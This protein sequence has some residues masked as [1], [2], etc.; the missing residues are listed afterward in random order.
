MNYKGFN[1]AVHEMGHNVEQTFSLNDVDSTLPPGRAEHRL[2]RG[3]RLRLPGARPRAA[4]PRQAR[5]EEPGA[6]DAERLLDDL[7]DRRRGARRH[8]R[9]ALD[10]RPPRRD[11][12]AAEGGDAPD[13]PRPLEQVLRA[14]LREEGRRPDARHLLPHDRLV[15]LPA[16]L[17]DRP[18][19][20]VPDRA[21]D[22]E[23][24]Q[25]RPR[26]RA[27]GED[28]QRRPGH[29]DEAGDRRSRRR[30]GAARGDGE[31][32]R[33]RRRSSRR[34]PWATTTR[35][36]PSIPCR[37][38]GRRRRAAGA[39]PPRSSRWTS[40]PSRIRAR[41]AATTR[42]TS[43]SRASTA[44][45]ARCSRTCPR[46]SCRRATPRPSTA[47]SWPTASAARRPAR[48]PAGPRSTALVDLVIDTPDWI[49]RL[50]EPLAE[51]VLQ[52]MERRFQK[53]REVLVE[54]AKA[55]PTPARHGH[56]ADARLQ[57]RPGAPDRARRRLARVPLPATAGSRA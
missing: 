10:V 7:R 21:A 30:A 23:G 1:I 25:P 45:C 22:G 46:A 53:V 50:D 13:L 8:G 15:P 54:R 56:D 5:R 2:H 55:D 31:G 48:S 43:S 32:A 3:A 37:S 16:R 42:T 40:R 27:D 33:G 17:P 34:R 38:R 14:G 41:S 35:T 18:P 47:C 4:R 51:E 20:R 52:R 12:R 19:D 44:R 36:P 28:R 49:M 29:L 26:V 11:A 57:P 6:E 39:A 24:A 9:L